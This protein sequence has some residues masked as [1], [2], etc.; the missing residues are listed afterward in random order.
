MLREAGYDHARFRATQ[1]AL[2]LAAPSGPT[3]EDLRLWTLAVFFRSSWR[4]RHSRARGSVVLTGSRCAPPPCRCTTTPRPR[5]RRRE[6][7]VR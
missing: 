1:L 6:R 4:W 5:H 7:A 3:L 2:P